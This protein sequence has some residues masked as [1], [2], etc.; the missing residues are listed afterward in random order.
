MEHQKVKKQSF[1]ECIPK[2]PLI[3]KEY[4]KLFEG[5]LSQSGQGTFDRME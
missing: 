1:P 4:L 5:S 3:R 2:K